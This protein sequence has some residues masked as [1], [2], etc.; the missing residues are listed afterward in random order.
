[1]R[2]VSRGIDILRHKMK[3]LDQSGDAI[4]ISPQKEMKNDERSNATE[5]I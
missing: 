4:A 2:T 5:S 3:Q 1:M